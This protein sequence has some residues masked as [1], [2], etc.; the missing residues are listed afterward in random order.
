[1]KIRTILSPA[2]VAMLALSTAACGGGSDEPEAAAAEEGGLA[3]VTLT[4]LAIGQIAPMVLAE[5]EGIF[6]KHGIDLEITFA[7][8][9][10]LVPS[11]MSGDAD[12]IWGNPP[13]VLAARA[14]NVPI[15]SVTTASVAGDDPASF[16]IQVMVAPDS[17]IKTLEDLDGKKVATASL[18]QLPDLALME[19]LGKAGV[20][21]S[22]VEFVEIPFPN[23]GET[24]AAGRVDAIISTEPFVTILKSSGA[25]VPLVSV[26]EGLAAT[27]PISAILSSEKF[28]NEN[29]DVVDDFRAAVDEATEYGLAHDD[30]V[31]AVIPTI[32]EVPEELAGVISLAPMDTTDD[33]AAWDAWADLLVQVGVIDE[34]PDSADAF[35][36]D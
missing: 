19:S 23:M 25:A 13:A 32:T 34:K 20:D 30:E 31:R 11:L 26:S 4:S 5:K 35:L 29:A 18:F 1:M 10:A 21:A 28:I 16:P 3:Q 24:L 2:L 27:S 36:A 33:A 9:A 8:P 6:E 14:N 7:E 15:K 12:F 22:G 17:D